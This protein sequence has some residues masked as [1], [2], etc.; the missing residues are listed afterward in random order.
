MTKSDQLAL[1]EKRLSSLM[2]STVKEFDLTGV[3]VI[4]ILYCATVRIAN[5]L[6]AQPPVPP[7]PPQ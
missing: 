3:E 5:N 7:T 2:D 6:L 4:G 1:F